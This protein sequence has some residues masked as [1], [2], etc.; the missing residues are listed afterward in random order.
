MY[1]EMLN[2]WLTHTFN[3]FYEIGRTGGKKKILKH[4]PLATVDQF[5]KALEEALSERGLGEKIEGFCGSESIAFINL[6]EQDSLEIRPYDNCIH[7]TILVK[8]V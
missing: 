3:D 4:S 6:G 8:G 7:H 5:I 2:V 1:K